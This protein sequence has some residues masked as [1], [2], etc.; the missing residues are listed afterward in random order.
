MKYG[1]KFEVIDGVVRSIYV[2]DESI[3]LVED[4][5]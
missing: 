5:S 1:V 2:G 3:R 4:C